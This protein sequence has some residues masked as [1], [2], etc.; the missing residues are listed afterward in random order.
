MHARLKSD[1]SRIRDI[2]SKS[3]DLHA[4]GLAEVSA[5]LSLH[6][7]TLW[8]EVFEAAGKVKEKVYGRRIV[9][10]APLY[11]SNFC[12]SHCTSERFLR[13]N[14]PMSTYGIPKG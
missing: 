1:P 7:S 4:L 6:D 13:Y 5:L 2:L 10:F 3:L 11:L 8:E 9:L 14:H 12:S